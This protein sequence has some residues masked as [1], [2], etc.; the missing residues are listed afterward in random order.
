[1]VLLLLFVRPNIVIPSF[2][3][4]P[5]TIPP[6]FI[7]I[8]LFWNKLILSFSSFSFNIGPLLI[9]S[10]FICL[11]EPSGWVTS[12]SFLW[13]VICTCWFAL[14]VSWRPLGLGDL[15]LPSLLFVVCFESGRGL[16]LAFDCATYV[17]KV[18]YCEW[19]I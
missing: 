11:I 3:S 2:I 19:V 8:S 5:P 7:V 17:L 14:I 6:G 18:I 13:D 16:S 9:I 1:M 10:S 12:F 15:I 4:L